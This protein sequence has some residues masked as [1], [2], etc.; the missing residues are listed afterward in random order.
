MVA[1]SLVASLL[2]GEVTGYHW[3]TG[4][5]YVSLILPNVVS[6]FYENEGKRRFV[7]AFKIL[8]GLAC[9]ISH[10]CHERDQNLIKE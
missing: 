6:S 5:I 8:I 10:L 4:I 7:I 9:L 2:G 1:S 3:Y